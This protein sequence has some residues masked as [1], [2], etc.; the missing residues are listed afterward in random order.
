MSLIVIA[1][2]GGA[3]TVLS[4]CILPVVPF[5]FAR[6]DKPFVTDRLPL[7]VGLAGTF[8][9]ATGLGLAG[10][11]GAAQ[12][13]QYGRW[14]ALATLALFGAALLFPSVADRLTRPLSALADRIVARSETQGATRRI[15]S[16][17]LLGAATGLLWAPC[18]GPILGVILTGAALH[19]AS[20]HTAAA[21]AAYAA[22]AASSLAIASSL[23]KRALD[24]V[25]RSLG[26]GEHVRRAMGA[27]VLLTVAA[28][29]TG[30]DTRVL[31]L[32]PGAP[33]NGI[34]SRLVGALKTKQATHD[35]G[36]RA[37]IMRVSTQAALPVQGRLPSLDGATT[38]LNSA[39]LSANELRGKVVVVNF[40]TYSCINCLR[41]LPYLKTWAQRYA[42]DGLVVIGVHTP[43]FGFERDTG[44]V[45]RALANLNI[46]YPVAIDNDY[47]IWRAFGNQYWP[48][49]YIV[50]AQGRVRFHH[51]GEGGYGEA[52]DAIRSLLADNGKTAPAHDAQAVQASGAQAA[53]DAANIGS[54]ETYVGYKQA[55]GFASPQRVRPDAV[56]AYSLPTQLALNEWALAGQWNVGGEAA[57]TAGPRA[58]IAYRFHARDLHLVL[59]PSANGKPVR[60][61]VTIDGAAPGASHGADV[62]AD[63][64]GVVTSARLYQ[65]VRQTGAVEDRT[66]QIEFLDS[67]AQ[68]YSFTFG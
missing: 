45:K 48:A 43:E 18:A 34:E 52:E 58:G 5:V 37:R 26:I 20:W 56:E 36:Q 14:I 65:L 60:F 53:A 7:L 62:A 21:L 61:R 22:G 40:W 15:A 25:K 27:L 33:T 63:G 10:L 39:P 38:W 9:L 12:L 4:P 64:S 51:F 29:A 49:F 54:G 2:L 32:I 31:A 3:F 19:G 17:M 55:Q 57:V 1:F 59:A 24:T 30:L 47:G 66:F 35:R 41:T 46:R 16:S 13:S 68:A 42:D 44:N 23:G 8:A 6:S 11:A 50:D 67:G 28:I